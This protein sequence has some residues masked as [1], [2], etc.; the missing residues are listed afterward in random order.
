M[1]TD[2]SQPGLASP[3]SPHDPCKMF[4]GGLSWQTTQEGL[5]EYF[6]QFG[7]VKECLVMRDPL[8]KRSRGFGFVTFMD[9]AGVDKVLAQS[10]HELDSKTIDP[11][12]A[13]PRRAQPKM[14]TR[15]KKIFV[16]G[17]SVNTTVED[18]KQ[19]FEQFG[20]VDDAMLMF[21]KTTNRHRGFG[22]VTFESEDIVEKVCEIHFHEINNKMVE[23]KKAQPKEVM[24][25]TGSARGRSR[26]MPYG[27]D[28][29]MLGIGMLGY[30]GFQ[31]AT[32]ASRSYTGIAPG[33]TYQFPAIPLT[34]YG[35]MA[36]AA[37]AAAVVRGTGSTPSRTGG[38][39]GTTSP[40]PM[41][42]LYGAANQDSGVSSY[43]SAASPAPSTGFGHS[44][45]GPL[46]AT[47]FTNGYH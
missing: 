12:V 1:E 42:E 18:V 23:C 13:F 31:A 3:D 24:S 20:K 27:M 35:P 47:A 41:A 45:G 28:A 43:I 44:L 32:Y 2:G 29:F 15:T 38:F 7:E 19:Y 37:A 5:R 10:R 46:I 4:I 8:T 25:P 6:S 9:Q 17:L 16:G 30:P 39:L 22:F 34:A 36:A 33:Y 11:K 26:V 14:V 40:G 21:D